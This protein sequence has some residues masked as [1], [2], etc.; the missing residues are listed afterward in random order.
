MILVLFLLFIVF[1]LFARFHFCISIARE[2]DIRARITCQKIGCVCYFIQTCRTFTDMLHIPIH[3]H[4]L[5]T[6]NRV[7]VLSSSLV[8]G[9]FKICTTIPISN[10][11]RFVSSI[12]QNWFVLLLAVEITKLLNQ[13]KSHCHDHPLKLLSLHTQFR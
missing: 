6:Y 8:P 9:L 4:T 13:I 3:T 2:Q 12:Q 7:N 5:A 1:E 10:D 11:I